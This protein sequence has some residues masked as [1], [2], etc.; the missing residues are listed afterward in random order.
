MHS[1]AATV[2]AP[3]SPSNVTSLHALKSVLGSAGE[4]LGDIV[5]WTLT[6]ASTDRATLENIWCS[7]GLPHELLPEPPSAEKALK[8]S[9]RTCQVGQPDWLIRLGKEDE[10]ELIFAVLYEERLGDG[11]VSHQQQA[12]IILDRRSEHL[13]SDN[14][15]H[16]LV[17]SIQD[18]FSQLR[19]THTADDVRRAI[20][21]ALRSFAAVTLRE[22]GGVYW[23]P[24]T[25]AA[26]LRKL[27]RA[28][29]QLGSSCFHLV[30]VH[31]TGA[32]AK[33]LGAVAKGS[34]EAE[35]AAL[36]AELVEFQANPPDRASTLERRL[37]TFE[38]LRA[39]SQLYRDILKVQVDDLEHHLS[40]MTASVEQLIAG[41]ALA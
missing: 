26:A 2:S 1:N 16:K 12:R 40:E 37:G 41:R 24:R 22:G 17:T 10:H 25:Y 13:S 34:L 39:R 27:E 28:V 6:E 11:S 8:N 20:V 5:W 14:G 7:A 32:A 35:L 18:T 36:Q 33:T 9:V 4:H 38:Q 29:N 31:E 15:T 21:K 19:N 30:P 3:S 23:V